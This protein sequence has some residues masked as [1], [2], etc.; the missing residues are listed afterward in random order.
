[1][2]YTNEGI[3]FSRIQNQRHKKYSADNL[4]L[5]AI[6]CTYYGYVMVQI[7]TLWVWLVFFIIQFLPC[8]YLA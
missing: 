5:G 8:T 1:M 4:F 6:I 3:H 2:F 7:Q